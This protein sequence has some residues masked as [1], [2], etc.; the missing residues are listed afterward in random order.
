MANK[1]LGPIMKHFRKTC[2]K[3]ID[4]KNNLKK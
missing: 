2:F 1:K 4:F 3:K